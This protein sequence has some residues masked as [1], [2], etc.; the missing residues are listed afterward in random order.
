MNAEYKWLVNVPVATLWTSHDSARLIDQQ[1]VAAPADIE[2]WIKGLTYD[3]SLALC[4]MNLVQSQLLFGE[5]VIVIEEKGDWVHVLVPSQ[6]SSKDERG[7]PGWLP[8]KQLG[9]RSDWAIDQGSI[10][11]IRAK[12]TVLSLSDDEELLLSYLT[13]LP[14]ML[15]DGEN[16]V[17]QTPEGK[18]TLLKIDVSIHPSLNDIP[19]GDGAGIVTAGEQFL[20]LPY[21]WGGMSSFGYDCSGLSYAVCKANGYIIPRDA[22]DQ[23]EAGDEVSLTNLQPGDLLF[24]AYEEGKGSLHHVGIYYGDGQLLHSPNTGKTIEI[25]DLKGTVYEKELC[26]ARRYWQKAG[27]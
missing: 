15:E 8:K 6:A 12:K 4:D 24:F 1:A 25:I 2:G 16:V 20:H 17:V 11:V 5:E 19:K 13:V 10:A 23:A 27:E 18:G 22:H 21:L 9:K 14:V 26:A 7:Y 3:K